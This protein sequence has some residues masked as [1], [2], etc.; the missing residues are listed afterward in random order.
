MIRSSR[1]GNGFH[2]LIVSTNFKFVTDPGIRLFDIELYN[3]TM[4]KFTSWEDFILKNPKTAILDE[5]QESVMNGLIYEREDATDNYKNLA[6]N[7][8][9]VMLTQDPIFKGIQAT[10]FHTLLGDGIT[11]ERI[12]AMDLMGFGAKATPIRFNLEG[13][14]FSSK[15]KV[16]ETS[17]KECMKIFEGMESEDLTPST[18]NKV[19]IRSFAIIPP[20]IS[21]VVI[22]NLKVGLIEM[23]ALFIDS[24][25]PTESELRAEDIKS[26]VDSFYEF[27]IFIWYISKGKYLMETN[28]TPVP[29]G[30]EE[31]NWA[32]MVHSSWIIDSSSPS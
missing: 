21:E 10:F 7:P 13:N 8:I 18:S 15:P 9:L 5:K 30:S 32:D 3:P 19:K 2:K 4:T 24:I 1:A 14:I 29:I 11:D 17:S 12:S 6:R 31:S 25:N 23:L 16:E 26:L 20:S 28:I 27:I 22:N